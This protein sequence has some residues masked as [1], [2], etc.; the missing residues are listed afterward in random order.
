MSLV[1]PFLDS[2]EP[3]SEHCRLTTPTGIMIAGV[4]GEALPN[5]YFDKD[6]NAKIAAAL[7]KI[8]DDLE[9]AP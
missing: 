9:A 7:R 8:A 3:W 6:K 5:S 2:L 4:I 1:K